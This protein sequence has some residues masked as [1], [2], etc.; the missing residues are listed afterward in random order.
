MLYC[1]QPAGGHPGFI[2]AQSTR[3]AQISPSFCALWL[4]KDSENCGKNTKIRS[5]ANVG[6]P[7]NVRH[8]PDDVTVCLNRRT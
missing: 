7:A 5:A 1:S 3:V 2:S 4:K 6:H 8:R